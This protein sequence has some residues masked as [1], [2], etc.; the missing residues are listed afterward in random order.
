MP[1]N[2]AAK[3]TSPGTGKFAG[4]LPAGFMKLLVTALFCL[5]AAGAARAQTAPAAPADSARLSY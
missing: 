3:Q 1:G 2:R 5:L 4:I